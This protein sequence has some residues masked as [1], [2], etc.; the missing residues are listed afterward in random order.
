MSK[1]FRSSADF[2]YV[3]QIF[4]TIAPT[5]L[6][7]ESPPAV[8][9]KSPPMVIILNRNKRK[10]GEKRKEDQYDENRC[11]F[12]LIT[13]HCAFYSRRAC[14][15]KDACKC[16]GFQHAFHTDDSITIQQTQV[17]VDRYGPQ[18]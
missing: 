3:L 5:S 13:L 12:D 10:E 2:L 16:L 18:K 11:C 17:F 9:S 8:A 15:L 1:Q 6:S 14:L 7:L 4:N